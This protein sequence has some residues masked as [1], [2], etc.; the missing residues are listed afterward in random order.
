V[1]KPAIL[2]VLLFFF[3]LLIS[4]H[5]H[6]LVQGHVT[7]SNQNPIVGARV[8]FTEESSPYTS[9]SAYTN[10]D[11]FY[12]IDFSVSVS[13]DVLVSF[14]LGQNYPNPFNPST[15]IPFSLD[16]SSHISLTVYNIMGQKVATVLAN[17]MSAGNHSVNWN[18]MDDQG[19]HVSSGIYFY[20]LKAGNSV[21]TGKMMLVR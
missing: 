18:G 11:G 5:A 20:R 15:T 7:D 8:T 10:K 6:A 9:Y 21:S 1:R 4:V 2:S 17:H 16:T 3:S 14:E 19:N 13:E 12:Q